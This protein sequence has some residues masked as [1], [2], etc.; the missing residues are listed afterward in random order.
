[1]RKVLPFVIVSVICLLAGGVLGFMIRNYQSNKQN[2]LILYEFYTGIEEVIGQ[3]ANGYAQYYLLGDD[4]DPNYYRAYGS[5]IGAAY[6]L[7]EVSRILAPLGWELR[8]CTMEQH[9][10]Q[11]ENAAKQVIETGQWQ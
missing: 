9:F 8:Q 11:I 5:A 7:S 6:T 3:T 1:M 4:T 10:N 2:N